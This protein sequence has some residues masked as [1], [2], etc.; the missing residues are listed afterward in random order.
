MDE[1]SKLEAR[2]RRVRNSLVHGGP[3][4]DQASSGALPFVEALAESALFISVDGRLDGVDL[5]DHFLERRAWNLK[6]LHA[7]QAG[8]PPVDAL[9]PNQEPVG[10]SSSGGP[11]P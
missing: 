6:C 5:V 11:G 4:I 1:F 2:S 3:A 9:W 10:E 7:L 8:V